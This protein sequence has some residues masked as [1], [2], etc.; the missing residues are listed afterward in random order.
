VKD[1]L[2]SLKGLGWQLGIP[3]AELRAIAA[4]VE[5]FYNEFPRR[6]PGRPDRIIDNPN[7]RLKEVQRQAR[8][9]FLE[10]M[11][12]D[13]AAHGCVKGRSARS[14]A[15]VHCGQK[16]L[17][18]IDIK[19]CFPSVTNRMVFRLLRRASFGPRAASLLTVL[20]T[21]KGHIPQG[22]PTSDRLANL[23]LMPVDQR[24]QQIAASLNL[25]NRRFVDDF[26]LSG[27][28]TRP[29]IGQVIA[30]LQ[31]EGFA[32]GHKKTGNAGAKTPHVATGYAATQHGLKVPRGKQQEI[33]T[34][35]FRTIQAHRMGQCDEFFLRSVRGSLAYLRPTNPGLTRRLERQLTNAGISL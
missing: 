35:V 17:A 13:D 3:L 22:A 5:Q 12:L 15:E 27:D 26:T 21:R 20:M 4:D 32:V 28:A 8:R 23:V 34:R 29:A 14:N 25:N 10:P 30:A 19:N 18:R 33:R 6:R 11:P 7:P 16:N 31:A 2:H 9:L 1:E 24:V